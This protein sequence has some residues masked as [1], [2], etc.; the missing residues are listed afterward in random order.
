[1][2]PLSSKV[3]HQYRVVN[4]GLSQVVKFGLSLLNIE[5]QKVYD[6]ICIKKP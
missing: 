2:I 1:M 6:H 4:I 5:S 3:Y